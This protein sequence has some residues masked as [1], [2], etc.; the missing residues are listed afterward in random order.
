MRSDFFSNTLI[1]FTKRLG[2]WVFSL[3]VWVISTGY[4][5][6][7]PKRV[8]VSVRFYR[9]LYPGKS[10]L[11]HLW[12]T[13]RQYHNFTNNYI[14]R[15]MLRELQDI[16]YT[17]SGHEN[18]REAYKKKIGGIIVMSHLGNWEIAS[19]VL[20]KE[21]FKFMLYMG[22]KQ[23]EQVE[24]MKKKNLSLSGIEV[25]AIDK[26]SSSPFAIID[27]VNFI[28]NGGFICLTGDRIWNEHQRSV[29]V[30][31]LGHNVLLPEAPHVIALM[32][33][34]PLFFFFCSQSGKNRYQFYMS[35]PYYVRASSRKDRKEAILKSTQ[36]YADL[37]ESHLRK[38]PLEWYHFE[39]FIHN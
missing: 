20:K 11:F 9:V 22:I 16:T 30:S 8:L 36:Y 15:F 10:W 38:H 33:G 1:F 12:C 17:T 6:F 29:E 39:Q 5:L 37:L 27:G 13:W 32:A 2:F 26:G 24:R 35:E 3:I 4:F 21:G 14:D 25:T 7:F 31:F 23:K 19:H 18:L 28:K 34:A